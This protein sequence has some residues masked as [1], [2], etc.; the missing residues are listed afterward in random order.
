MTKKELEERL[1]RLGAGPVGSDLAPQVLYLRKKVNILTNYI[2]Q[3]EI[4]PRKSNV[5]EEEV[6][7]GKK[8]DPEKIP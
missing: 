5:K 1:D 2:L 3:H 7:E 6:A 4:A 8:D